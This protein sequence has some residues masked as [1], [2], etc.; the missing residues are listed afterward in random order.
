MHVLEV[1]MVVHSIFHHVEAIS[2]ILLHVD[3][4]EQTGNETSTEDV[5][6][7]GGCNLEQWAAGGVNPNGR[8][9]R[10]LEEV[11][12]ESIHENFGDHFITQLNFLLFALLIHF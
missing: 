7:L 1:L 3:V 2:H 10:D 4:H 11:D 8:E 12:D 6:A 5:Y 9:H